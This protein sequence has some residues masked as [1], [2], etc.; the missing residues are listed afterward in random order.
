MVMGFIVR[1]TWQQKGSRGWEPTVDSLSTMG[2][3][4]LG[5]GSKVRM[6]RWAGPQPNSAIFSLIQHT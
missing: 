2:R 1:Q 5:G 3:A 4:E 6:V